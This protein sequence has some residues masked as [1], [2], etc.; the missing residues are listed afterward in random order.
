MRKQLLTAGFA[1]IMAV[2]T[3]AGAQRIYVQTGPPVAEREV[4]P[5][6]PHEGWV[7]RQGYHRYD[8][9]RYV[10]V[11]G[12]YAE[13]PYRRAHWVPGHWVRERRGYYWEEGHWR[14]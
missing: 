11:P 8:G 14:H 10:W 9:G 3:A 12:S 4:V 7:W 6:P 13:P 2:A 1:A 5:P